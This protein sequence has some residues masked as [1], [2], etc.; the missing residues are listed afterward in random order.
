MNAAFYST[1]PSRVPP[2]PSPGFRSISGKSFSL[3]RTQPTPD[4]ELDEYPFPAAGSLGRS[5]NWT[6]LDRPLPDSAPVALEDA[7]L[8]Q[9]DDSVEEDDSCDPTLTPLDISL[10]KIG[11]G[12]YQFQLLFLCGAGFCADN[13]WLNAIAGT[14]CPRSDEL[15]FL[16]LFPFLSHSPSRATFVL[17]RR[18][19]TRRVLTL[20]TLNR[21]LRHHRSLDW[22]VVR[23]NFRWNDARS[24]RL[25]ILYVSTS[26]NNLCIAG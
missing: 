12:K 24:C 5:K 17:S 14:S 1:S 20:V 18:T 19:F 25:G 10:E 3:G 4:A 16:T 9:D 11:M 22:S 23:I 2:R 26:A 15:R 8:A 21:T 7:E 6:K 13:M